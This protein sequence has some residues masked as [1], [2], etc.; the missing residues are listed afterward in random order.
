M[1]R[2]Q[3]LETV[4][5]ARSKSFVPTPYLSLDCFTNCALDSKRRTVTLHE[6]AS[7]LF[8][9]C[10]TFGGTWLHS[11]QAEIETLAKRFDLIG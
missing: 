1:T 9:H 11:E 3:W 8:G 5:L 7:L 2:K 6:A 4:T 10:A